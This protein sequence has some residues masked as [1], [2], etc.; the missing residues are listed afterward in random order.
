[1]AYPHRV[2]VQLRIAY[3]TFAD[4]DIS[5]VMPEVSARDG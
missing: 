5:H 1:L 2:G 4:Q 3:V